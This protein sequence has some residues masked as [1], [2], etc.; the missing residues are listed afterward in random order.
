MASYTISPI[1]GAGAQLFDNNGNPLSGGKIY[2]Y[3]AGSTTPLTTYTTP[4]GSIANSNPIIANAAGR[5]TDEIWFPVSGAY[6]FVLKDANDVLLATYDNIPTTPQPP[7]VNDASS[8]S[9]EQG[10]EVDAGNFTIGSTYLITSVGTTDFVAIGAAANVTGI[11]F[12]ATGV[13]SGTGK[14]AFSQTVQQKLQ[15]TLSVKDFGAVGDG[16]TDDTVAIQAAISAVNSDASISTLIF[17]GVFLV[18]YLTANTLCSISRSDLTITGGGTIKAKP[19]AYD[20]GV[21]AGGYKYYTTFY[22]TGDRVT[23]ENITIDGNNQFSQYASSGV[24]PNY[25]LGAV[26]FQGTNYSVLLQM[27]KAINVRY[28]NGGG[29]PIKGTYCYQGLI[30]S[31]EVTNSQGV[32]FD[33]SSLCV[34]SNNSSYNAYDAHFATWNSIGGVVSNNTCNTS[35]NGSGIDVSGSKDCTIIGNT[36]RACANRGIWVVQDPNTGRQPSN[37]TIVGNTFFNN[38]S[39]T[40][41]IEK[42]DIQVAAAYPS[43]DTRPSGTVD[44]NGLTIIGNTFTTYNGANSITLGSYAY[45]VLIDGNT[46]KSDPVTPATRSI[47]F[48]NSNQAIVRNNNDLIYA[49]TN[50]PPKI[51]GSGPLYY[52]GVDVPL[53]STASPDSLGVVQQTFIKETN[54]SDVSGNTYQIE[55]RFGYAEYGAEFVSANGSKDVVE[56]EFT[57]AGYEIAAIE[58]IV[59]VAGNRGVVSSRVAY[60]STNVTTPT[61]I[62][63]ASTL[64]SGGATI[65][66][67]SYTATTGKVTIAVTSNTAIESS[68]WMRVSGTAGTI[69]NIISLV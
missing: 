4:I 29:W 19:E 27:P 59:T 52:D 48:Y 56:I 2:T 1:W 42:G 12:T 49:V 45:N 50:N 14:A 47:V 24:L 39:Y 65:P 3:Y 23:I 21:S 31:C 35:S 51:I 32:G 26:V 18:N 6:K 58:L 40:P 41:I 37:V 16:V 10:Y 69:P 22:V 30:D 43:L 34:V 46:F 61:Q 55:E 57:G 66:S 38:N 13:G 36:I 54:R 20:T 62:V 33:G 5:L 9:Y 44:V 63:A 53:D 7:I 67:I 11:L 28:I 17:D 15:Q 8:I 60:Q 25:W 64:F 68:I